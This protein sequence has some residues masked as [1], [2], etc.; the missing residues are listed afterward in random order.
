MKNNIIRN[1]AQ[2]ETP[3][4]SAQLLEE[5]FVLLDDYFNGKLS[6]EGERIAYELP[7]GQK[8]FICANAK[9]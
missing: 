6:N 9:N 3:I 4:T 2:T 8:F 1:E 7:N 5:I